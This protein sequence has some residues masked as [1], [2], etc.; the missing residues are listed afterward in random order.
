[1]EIPHLTDGAIEAIIN[2]KKFDK[3][4]LKIL[5]LQPI[6]NYH[7]VSYKV[8]LWDGQQAVTFIM[9][10]RNIKELL[11]K[12]AIG[13]NQQVVRLDEYVY[14]KEND[15]HVIVFLRLT[16]LNEES[17]RGRLLQNHVAAS[18]AVGAPS[19]EAAA[20]QSSAETA[21]HAPPVDK[22]VPIAMLSSDGYSSREWTITAT[23]VEKSEEV[24]FK[25]GKGKFF[26]MYL[27]DQ[28]GEIRAVAFHSHCDR[29]FGCF[30]KNKKYDISN[31][32]VQESTRGN[33]DYEIV[34]D[35]GTKVK[36]HQ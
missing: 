24:P 13:V 18:S 21:R 25:N 2:E 4:V 3:P 30:H 32:K 31:G 7:L 5:H 19:A 36:E 1:M 28:S 29:L 16:A 10:G 22:I 27:R 11:N 8:V 26:E 23:V 17:S 12:E 6:S 33:T 35:W 14:Y 15:R 20:L 34:L 9:Q